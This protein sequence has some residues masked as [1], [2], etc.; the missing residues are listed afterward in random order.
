M[1]NYALKYP[2]INLSSFSFITETN[3][4]IVHMIT[5]NDITNIA[6]LNI[7]FEE[8][9]R[10]LQHG[11][12]IGVDETM[13]RI[14]L[15]HHNNTSIE[16]M[17]TSLDKYTQQKLKTA[18]T[19]AETTPGELLLKLINEPDNMLAYPIIGKTTSR[20]AYQEPLQYKTLTE[21][22]TTIYELV[23]QPNSNKILANK[24]KSLNAYMKTK[25]IDFTGKA[26]GA[27]G[28]EYTVF[29]AAKYTA[30]NGG[31][32]DNQRNDLETFAEA[33]TRIPASDNI[34]M[35]LLADGA[36]YNSMPHY[37]HQSFYD[38]MRS[39]YASIYNTRLIAT[40]TTDFDVNMNAMLTRI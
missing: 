15:M 22:S 30:A 4:I 35:V 14:R 31:A 1:I 23:N 8:K 37:N 10:E 3:A 12:N 20:M 27:S 17:I 40:T 24:L 18:A 21:Q 9:A 34:I 36:Y 7:D 26:Q 28:I 38:A 19:Y 13:T 6:K 16:S 11:N 33:A 5:G 29:V 32:Q 25:S 2:I 39:Q